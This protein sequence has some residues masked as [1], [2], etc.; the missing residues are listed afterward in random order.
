MSRGRSPLKIRRARISL[1]YIGHVPPAV[2]REQISMLKSAYRVSRRRT[3]RGT[4]T[5]SPFFFPGTA[6]GSPKHRVPV[7][8][9][10]EVRLA[11]R[12]RHSRRGGNVADAAH[13]E[14]VSAS[15]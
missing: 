13:G 1:S 8:D 14:F 7:W 15:G 4:D 3:A 5:L 10:G 9:V 12:V 2:S 11:V 6:L